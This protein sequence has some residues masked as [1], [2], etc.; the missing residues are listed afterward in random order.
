VTK[1]TASVNLE[2]ITGD[3]RE[4]VKDAVS[5]E[6]P[7]TIILN[8]RELVTVLATPV[9][10]DYLAVGYLCSEGL[11]HDRKNLKKVTIDDKRGVARVETEGE[12]EPSADY[13][14][15]RLIT[16]GCGG[17]PSFY[18]A[19]DVIEPIEFKTEVFIKAADIFSAMKEFQKR[20]DVFRDTGGV[21]S[22]A[23]RNPDGKLVFNEDIGRHNAV[24]KVFGE[25]FIKELPLTGCVLL[26][27]GRISS[28]ILIKTA[29]REIPLLASR[30]APTD[31]SIGLAERLGIT[32]IGFV[33]GERMNIY[34][35]AWRVT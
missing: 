17:G 15:Q 31:A 13:L 3:K 11:L 33:R 20:S 14:S 2:R 9:N 4:R 16:S 1:A 8:D 26:S 28:E 32:L 10:Q 34:S 18:R 12:P 21:H 5:C 23:V 29:R 7:L 19:A 27:S 24:D 25:C 30:S 22:A 6:K 35:G